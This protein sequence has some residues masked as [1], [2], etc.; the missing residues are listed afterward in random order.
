MTVFILLTSHTTTSYLLFS[1][2]FLNNDIYDLPEKPGGGGGIDDRS[3]GSFFSRAD[4]T[5][6]NC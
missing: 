5:R 1:K 6:S 3:I 4:S 2:D